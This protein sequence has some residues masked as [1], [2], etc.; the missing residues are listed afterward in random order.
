MKTAVEKVGA[1]LK[2]GSHLGLDRIMKLLELLGNPQKEL[3]VIH[4]A[5]TNG[6]G[7]CC[8]YIYEILEANGYKA[9]LYTSP[10]IE[11]FNERIEFHGEY[12]SDEDLEGCT[13]KVCAA[14]EKMVAEG[15]DSPTEFEVV[16]AIAVLYFQ[17]K[18]A[19]FV[20]LEVGLGGRGDSTNITDSP[21]VSVITSVSYDHMDRLGNTIEE[22]AW[23]KA[24]I[25]K[26]KVPVVAGVK[27]V[28]AAKVIAKEAYQKGCVLYDCSKYK[29]TLKKSDVEGSL[30]DAVIDNEEYGNVTISMKGEHQVDNALCALTTI[31]ILRKSG[32]IEVERSRLDIGLK[33]AMQKGRFEVFWGTVTYVLDGAHNQ[34]GM[35]S[36]VKTMDDCFY[37]KKV[38]TVMGV[39]ADKAI[40]DI[41]EMAAYLG[42][43]FIITEPDNPRKLEAEI[44]AG[45]LM[46]KGANCTV[47]ATGKEALAEAEERAKNY[48]VVL[49]AGSLYLIGELRR[50]IKNV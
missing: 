14:A 29:K 2:F 44:L 16:T 1:F 20:V 49:C 23:E 4:V 28:S 41:V 6:K 9:G 19:D 42:K 15:G 22:I 38:L 13:D 36:L 35:E 8:R 24:G 39:L 40:D 17:Q 11:V 48:D 26:P 45:K 31:E 10:F 21:L 27:N 34:E 12:I 30:F 47:K 7:S 25:I 5:G 32:I 18:K 50:L 43:D 33:K 46:Q 3:K 37:G